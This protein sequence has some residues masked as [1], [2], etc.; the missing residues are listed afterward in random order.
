MEEQKLSLGKD[1]LFDLDVIE[2]I[3]E[4]LDEQGQ[5]EKEYYVKIKC[6][7]KEEVREIIKLLEEKQTIEKKRIVISA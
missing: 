2:L 7:S 6:N 3:P 1:F 4:E 5:I